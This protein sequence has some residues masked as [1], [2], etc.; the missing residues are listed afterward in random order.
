MTETILDAAALRADGWL[1]RNA[2][3]FSA[4]VG[5]MWR[6]GERPN[7]EFAFLAEARH[8]NGAGIVHGGMIST[9]CDSAMSLA[10]HDVDPTPRLTINLAIQF[11]APGK[12]GELM[13][14]RSDVLRLTR[15]LCFLQGQVFGGAR[16][17]ASATATLKSLEIRGPSSPIPAH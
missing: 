4:L 12:I 13:I 7:L 2:G 8:A 17:V 1:E 14:A 5:P 15:S 9:F 3:G 16:L 10:A 11:I 6:R